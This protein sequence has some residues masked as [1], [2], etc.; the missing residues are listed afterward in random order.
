MATM[1]PCPNC[2]GQLRYSIEEKKLKCVS[3]GS[4][5]D[6]NEYTP[7][8]RINETTLNTNIFTCSTCGGE[9]QLIDND[10]MEF[11][12]FCGNQTVIHEKF[13][14]VGAPKYIIP[15]SIGNQL[16]KHNFEKYS[17]SMHFIPNGLNKEENIEKMVRMYIPYYIY[18]YKIDTDIKYEGEKDC[19]TIDYFITDTAEINVKLK[20]GDVMIPYDASQSFSD[21]IAANI[22]PFP[23]NYLQP[24]NPNYLA[25]SFV[26]NSSVDLDMYEDDAREYAIEKLAFQALNDDCGYTADADIAKRTVTENIKENLKPTDIS[27][28]YFPVYF[29]TTKFKDRVAYSIVNGANGEIYA[30]VPIDKKKMFISSAIASVIVFI[31]LFL[32][33]NLFNISFKIKGLCG[34]SAFFSGFI[35]LLGSYFSGKTDKAEKHKDDKG[36]F[37]SKEIK[38][39]YN[40]GT[41]QNAAKLLLSFLIV[42]ATSYVSHL[43]VIK[44]KETYDYSG[45]ILFLIGTVFILLSTLLVGFGNKKVLYYGFAGW[46]IAS[47]TRLLNYPNDLCYYA[48]L[49]ASFLVILI[50]INEIINEYNRFATHPIPQFFKKG[51]GIENA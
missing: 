20:V 14:A 48:A 9:I 39:T 35:A 16:I 38:K 43:E 30:D 2:G 28:A 25:G 10:G 23:I 50:S 27:G 4:L 1:F 42:L 47:L 18:R 15:F 26:E 7:D 40:H 44:M 21:T 31:L 12:P 46:M 45:G 32:F 3:C 19:S 29:L 8:E 34:V 33:N 17:N 49:F 5:V 41:M 37:I 51:G 22:E 13:S 24:F 11:C 6:V 36:Y